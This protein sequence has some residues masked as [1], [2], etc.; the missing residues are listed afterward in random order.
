MNKREKK[1][2]VWCLIAVCLLMTVVP[3]TN[4]AEKNYLNES[5][6]E[7][8][9]RMQWWRDARFGMFIHWGIYAV[10]GGIH[11]GRSLSGG[12]E[13][14]MASLQIPKDEYEK[15]ADQF[16]PTDFDADEWVRIAK[17]AGMKYIVIT[18]KHH[19]GFCLWDSDVTEYDV[20][21]A[22]PYDRDILQELE[23]ACNEHGVKLCF[24]Y[25]IMDWHHPDASGDSFPKYRDEYM[26][27]QLKELVERYDPAVLWFDG[28]WIKEWT[29]PQGKE[30]Y[31]YIRS[32]KPDII[33]NNRVGKGRQ[34]MQ[35]MNKGEGYAGD[36]G[37]PEQQ[38]PA[39]GLEGVDWESCLTMFHHWGY[40][41]NY[42]K[43][44]RS[45]DSFIRDLI[46]TT[47]KGGNCL[48]NVGPTPEGTFPPP[49]VQRLDQIGDWIETYGESIYGST[50]SPFTKTPWGRCTAKPGKL[51]LHVYDWP[52]DNKLVVPGLKNKVAS[53]YILGGMEG[54]KLSTTRKGDDVVID[55]PPKMDSVATVVV[56]E[57]E[58]EPEVLPWMARPDDA[59]TVTLKAEDADIKGANVRLEQKGENANIGYWTGEN[60]TV[61]W[62][63][64]VDKAETYKVQLSI[65][66]EAG[67]EGGTYQV[68]LD[69]KQLTGDVSKTEGWTDYE[70][71]SP[72]QVELEPGQ[73][74]LDVKPQKFGSGNALMNL[75]WVKLVPT[76]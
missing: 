75:E 1:S 55:V 37:T 44:L 42:Q 43:W 9:A 2:L 11:K 62:K 14:I 19:D 67:Y 17:D 72:G 57:I 30:L 40:H 16:N 47:S 26:K 48:L 18:S 69:G 65:S 45:G 41:K 68:A 23:D 29:E 76:D 3:P 13:W 50:A 6:A 36:F 59:G 64:K 71:V 63:F 28:E 66:C 60:D 4:A 20:I 31:N 25:S 35:G 73:Y 7:T 5:E 22:T 8:D 46:D 56:L 32:L 61:S 53:A 15:F 21:D 58:G 38:I 52:A 10:P 24:Y 74:N 51:Y 39:T 27:P 34:G 70:T 33:I 49:C 12:A 54:N